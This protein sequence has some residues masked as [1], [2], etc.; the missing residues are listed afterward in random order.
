MKL[1]LLTRCE[2]TY[3]SVVQNS[4]MKSEIEPQ[5]SSSSTETRFCTFCVRRKNKHKLF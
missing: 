4:V 5:E 1:H 3:F 2:I